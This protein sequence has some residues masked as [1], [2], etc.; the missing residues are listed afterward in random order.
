MKTPTLA[1]AIALSEKGEPHVIGRRAIDMMN[2]A[3]LEGDVAQIADYVPGIATVTSPFDKSDS[4]AFHEQT[5]SVARHCYVCDALCI[6]DID[7]DGCPMCEGDPS[8]WFLCDCQDSGGVE[9]PDCC[10]YHMYE[11]GVAWNYSYYS[12]DVLDWK[13][14]GTSQGEDD[15]L[16]ETIELHDIDNAV[17]AAEAW[18]KCST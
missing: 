10:T 13:T 11:N 16:K 2:R 8:A 5:I 1:E 7:D 15:S 12:D 6:G 4:D 18:G 3:K 14:K 9:D 17:R